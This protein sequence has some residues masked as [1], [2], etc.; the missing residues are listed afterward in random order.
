MGVVPIDFEIG[1]CAFPELAVKAQD[2]FNSRRALA[3][4]P[5][6]RVFEL[7]APLDQI[8]PVATGGVML[9]FMNM[10]R[11]AL[12]ANSASDWHNA[13]GRSYINQGAAAQV[14]I[15]FFQTQRGLTLTAAYPA[16]PIARASMR[17]YVQALKAACR[18][19]ANT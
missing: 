11:F 12:N 3:T 14:G 6:Q 19:V 9:S 10:N 2:T 5:L 7:A 1:H 4:V 16:N 18:R 8:R 17:D 15:W 13:N